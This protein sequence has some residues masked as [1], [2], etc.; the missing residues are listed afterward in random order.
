MNLEQPDVRLT[1]QIIAEKVKSIG[2]PTILDD[3]PPISKKSDVNEKYLAGISI[4][5]ILDYCNEI[6][7]LIIDI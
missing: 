5:L 6:L 3:L 4:I 1:S 7:L 2:K